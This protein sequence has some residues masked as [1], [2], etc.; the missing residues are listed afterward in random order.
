MSRPVAITVALLLILS[1]LAAWP[2]LAQGPGAPSG[3]GNAG[4]R[5]ATANAGRIFN[6]M[7]E[8]KDLQEK[9]KSEGQSLKSE[10][11][12]RQNKLKELQAARDLLKVGT[13]QYDDANRKLMQ[14]AIE[15]EVWGKMTQNDFQRSQKAQIKMLYDKVTAGIAEVAEQR[16]IQLVIATQQDDLENIESL[17][18]PQLSARLTARDVLYSAA[19]VDISND[20]LAVLDKK[21]KE[22]K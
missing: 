12:N 10:Q 8:T 5:I 11:D 3:G 7:Q 2:A 20:V 22:K 18:V 19:N 4:L 21:Y 6:E 1:A 17:T 15:F 16:G 9:I 13:P 14:S